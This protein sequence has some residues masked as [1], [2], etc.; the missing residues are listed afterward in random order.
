MLKMP[1]AEVWVS[2]DERFTETCRRLL[3]PTHVSAVVVVD[4]GFLRSP[5]DALTNLLS[6]LHSCGCAHLKVYCDIKQRGEGKAEKAANWA[7][8][9]ADR[10]ETL[11]TAFRAAVPPESRLK[12]ALTVFRHSGDF[13]DRFIVARRVGGDGGRSLSL[14]SGVR[15]LSSSKPRPIVAALVPHDAVSRHCAQDLRVWSKGDRHRPTRV[16]V[17]WK[18][19]DVLVES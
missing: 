1:T 13:H 10:T 17:Q 4:P 8:D 14:G 12:I 6:T 5:A 19:G 2:G 15:C 11:E 3:A 9:L 16:D 18:D 7:E